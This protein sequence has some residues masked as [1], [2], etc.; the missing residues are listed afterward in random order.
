LAATLGSDVVAAVPQARGIA[1]LGHAPLGGRVDIA[2]TLNYRNDDLLGR[3]VEMQADPAS[4]LYGHFLTN[5]QF[6][7]TF[8]PRPADYARV[9]AALQKN[10]FRITQTFSNA[11]VIDAR[12]TV[13]AADRL[14]STDIHTVN[15]AGYGIRY[16]NATPA[17]EP[18]VLRG[19]IRAVSGLHTLTLVHTHFWKATPHFGVEPDAAGP[20]LKGPVNP[21]YGIAG[22]G[23][24]AF[25]QGYLFPEQ[26]KSS[27][28]KYYDGTGR[29]SGIVI[30]ADFLDSDLAARGRRQ[31][32][33]GRNHTRRRVGSLER[34]R[35]RT[36]RI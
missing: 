15:Q 26:F 16:A 30:D 6:N 27:G 4:P 35:N 34:S 3:L 23:P 31:Q 14:F 19:L 9:A 10:G 5:A 33:F 1:D 2:V 13:G 8:A 11:T 29:T 22:Y 20:P 24:L 12:G 18:A 17:H 25:S 21:E 32:R 28:G 36:L 7:A